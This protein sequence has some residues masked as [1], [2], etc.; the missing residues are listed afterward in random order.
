MLSSLQQHRVPLN[1]APNSSPGRANSAF[2]RCPSLSTEASQCR[3]TR[4]PLPEHAPHYHRH[5]SGVSSCLLSTSV[6]LSLF[7][8][9]RDYSVLSSGCPQRLMNC[10][11]TSLPKLFIQHLDGSSVT[12]RP[13]S[14]NKA[15][16][17]ALEPVLHCVISTEQASSE[18]LSLS[19]ICSSTSTEQL[20]EYTLHA[21]SF[22]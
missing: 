8:E 2:K 20:P 17:S 13:P 4:D 18:R 12:S 7:I 16:H 22:H 21:Y 14:G 3:R 9:L 10:A 15:V 19:P 1:A 5:P 6:A 11:N